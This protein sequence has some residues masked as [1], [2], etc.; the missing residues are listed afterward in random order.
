MAFDRRRREEAEG[1]RRIIGSGR[2][3][4][5]LGLCA[6]VVLFAAAAAAACAAF[7]ALKGAA[8]F[9]TCEKSCESQRYIPISEMEAHT[10]GLIPRNTLFRSPILLSPL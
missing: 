7:R 10:V 3:T 2:R 5:A 9:R 6:K 8:S 4:G 1:D